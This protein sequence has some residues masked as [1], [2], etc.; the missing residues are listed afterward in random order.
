MTHG[1]DLMMGPDAISLYLPLFIFATGHA[2]P[3]YQKPP[4]LQ[5]FF[6]VHFRGVATMPQ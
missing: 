3:G 6:L 1:R 4:W 2:L 5:G